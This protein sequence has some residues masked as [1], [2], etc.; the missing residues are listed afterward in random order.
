ERALQDRERLVLLAAVEQGLADDRGEVGRRGG[1]PQLHL[2]ELGDHLEA[3]D[4]AVHLARARQ[5]LEVI[6]MELPCAL[7]QTESAIALGNHIL[8]ERGEL[9]QTF[10]L[11]GFG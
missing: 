6:R 1:T 7:I 3:A 10:R 2:T 9:E 5:R 11:L 8:D 4:L